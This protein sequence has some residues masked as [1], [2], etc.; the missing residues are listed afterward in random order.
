[1]DKNNGQQLEGDYEKGTDEK[2][3]ASPQ[4]QTI[5]QHASTCQEEIQPTHQENVQQPS[6][7]NENQQKETDSKDKKV[8]FN[9][10]RSLNESKGILKD[11]I[12]KPHSVINSNRSIS[13]E[14]SVIIFVLLSFIFYPWSVRIFLCEKP[15]GQYV[16]WFRKLFWQFDRD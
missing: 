11:A 16:W 2:S 7:V 15:Y 1:M 3:T 4:E 6:N 13:L 12:I 9:F 5:H 14:T 10:D 8:N